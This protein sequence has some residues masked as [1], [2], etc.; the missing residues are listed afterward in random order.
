MEQTFEYVY[1]DM[2]RYGDCDMHGHMNHAQFFT[3]MEQARVGYLQAIGF[4]PHSR[5]TIP[6][7]LVHASCD[8]KAPAYINDALNVAMGVTHLGSSSF[9]M[10]YAISHARSGELKATGKTVL[11]YYDYRKMKK[12]L[13]PDEFRRRV[14]A[15][16]A[17]PQK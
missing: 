12:T 11:V 9:T 7:I 5:D 10:E 8:Y 4:D 3:F 15:L 13:V 1:H 16:K 14:A 17:S 6:F 2:V